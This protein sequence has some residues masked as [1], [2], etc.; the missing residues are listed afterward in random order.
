MGCKAEGAAQGYTVLG[1]IVLLIYAI[2]RI[3]NGINSPGP[4]DFEGL[5]E[6]LLAIVLIVIVAL[7]FDACGFISWKVAKSG[8]LLALFGLIA[9]VIVSYPF[10]SFNPI[11]WL[12]SLPTLAGFMILLAG[13]LLLLRK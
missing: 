7:A 1:G 11:D 10:T 9:I 2:Q 13:I 4:G 8:L 6:I 12:Q 3:I 5:I